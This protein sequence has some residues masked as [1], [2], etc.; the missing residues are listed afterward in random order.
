[1]VK[2]RLMYEGQIDFKKKKKRK[3]VRERETREGGRRG[4]EKVTW[5][6]SGVGRRRGG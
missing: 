2:A 1:M 5:E 3:A 6:E 4:R